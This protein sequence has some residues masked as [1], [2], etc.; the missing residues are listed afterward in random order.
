M[1]NPLNN[2]CK[3]NEHYGV[4]QAARL[5]GVT[6]PTLYRYVKAGDIKPC[7]HTKKN[8]LR[9]KGSEL[10]KYYNSIS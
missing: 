6:K 10:I 8:S 4:V 1:E 5:L 9:I 3:P 7:L 2:N